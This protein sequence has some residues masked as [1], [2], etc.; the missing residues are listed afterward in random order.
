MIAGGNAAGRREGGKGGWE[1]QQNKLSHFQRCQDKT[2]GDDFWCRKLVVKHDVGGNDSVYG[3]VF[4][5]ASACV[6]VCLC[7]RGGA[8]MRREVEEGT[9][10]RCL[11]ERVV[12]CVMLGMR[13]NGGILVQVQVFERQVIGVQV[14]GNAMQGAGVGRQVWRDH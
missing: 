1:W 5:L 12:V 8:G 9:L 6:S 10:N 11:G 13:E 7:V 4:H 2:G 3:V 14:W